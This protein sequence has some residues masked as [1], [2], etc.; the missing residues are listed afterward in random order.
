VVAINMEIT[1]SVNIKVNQSMAGNL[2]QH[3]IKKTD[4]RVQ[5]RNPSAVQIDTHS[6]FCFCRLTHKLGTSW[7]AC[8]Q[9]LR[10]F[11]QWI[12]CHGSWRTA[13]DRST[14]IK[15]SANEL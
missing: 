11:C 10:Q 8:R 15:Q 13:K 6:D 9:G 4:A 2:I 7:Q 5:M 1:I 3:V 14:T 12:I